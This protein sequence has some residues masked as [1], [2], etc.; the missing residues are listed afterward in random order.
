MKRKFVF[1]FFLLVICMLPFG[2]EGQL[3]TSKTKDDNKAVMSC[4][5]NMPARFIQKTKKTSFTNSISNT[6]SRKGMIWI[7]G[8]KFSMGAADRKGKNDEYP[9]HEVKLDD[10]WIDK[11]EVTNARF[12]AFVQAT[13]YITTAEKKPDWEELKKQ[14]PAATPKPDDSLLVEASLVFIPTLHAVPLNDAS[15]WWQWKK[16]ANWMHPDGPGSSIVGKDNYPVV[17]V[18]WDDANAYAKWAGKRLPTEAEWEFAG[19]GGLI[20]QPY[21]WGSEEVESGKPK[22]NTWQGHFPDKNT[23]WDGY[24]ALAP[25]KSFSPNGYGLY[26]MAGNVWEWCADWY[27][28]DYYRHLAGHIAVNPQGPSSGYGQANA[29]IP[30]RVV[31]GGSFLC[32][33]SYCLG[34]R[35]SAR[36]GSSSDTGLENTGFRCVSSK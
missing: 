20:G 25:V 2:S 34:Y 24:A 19:R 35:V 11:N 16:G 17:H 4:H 15:Q 18:S 7:K 12:R 9:R 28:P 27:Q 22:A 3:F 21:S 26:D 6:R 14:V 29:D 5:V 8:G 32:N 30:R 36:M 23:S 31:R 13:G 33:A 1:I 10:F